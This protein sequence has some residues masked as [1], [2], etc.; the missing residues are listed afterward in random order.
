[1][2]LR[3]AGHRQAQEL[4]RLE[5]LAAQLDESIHR[6]RLMDD[7]EQEWVLLGKKKMQLGMM[8]LRRAIHRPQRF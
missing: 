7:V 3:V 2:T 5:H 6:L 8:C 4:D 1:M